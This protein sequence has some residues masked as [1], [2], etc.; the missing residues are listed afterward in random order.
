MIVFTISG[1]VKA[2]ARKEL[3]TLKTTAME[4]ASGNDNCGDAEDAIGASDGGDGSGDG[5]GADDNCDESIG[6][7]DDADENG[8]E[9]NSHDDDYFTPRV[10]VGRLIG[11]HCM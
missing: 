2:D 8:R 7:C 11:S 1:G 6:D 3:H 4:I 5:G 9:H 10:I